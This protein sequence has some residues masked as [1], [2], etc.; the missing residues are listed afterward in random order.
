MRAIEL[1]ARST[2]RSSPRMVAVP[3][4]LREERTRRSPSAA[5][6]RG[7]AHSGS[8]AR[9]ISWIR[10]TRRYADTTGASGRRT[11]QTWCARST[12]TFS[13]HS[14]KTLAL[15]SSMRPA[16]RAS[17]TS[18]SRHSRSSATPRRITAR[19]RDQASAARASSA[20]QSSSSSARLTA[21]AE[22]ARPASR[23]ARSSPAVAWLCWRYQARS[24]VTVSAPESRAVSTRA[25]AHARSAPGGIDARPSGRS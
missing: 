1:T 23:I 17:N 11:S 8:S 12:G 22:S 10:S 20:D 9:R 21:S 7:A 3:V 13:V 5:F 6:S 14:E 2:G 18:G 25:S 19:P 24:A 4:G 16:S 15:G